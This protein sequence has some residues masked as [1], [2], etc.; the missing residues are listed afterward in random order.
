MWPLLIASAFAQ[1]PSSLSSGMPQDRV[2]LLPEQ[3]GWS[4]TVLWHGDRIVVSDGNESL[5]YQASDLSLLDSHKVSSW[6]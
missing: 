3:Q 4:M 1:S 2:A 5:L 6:G